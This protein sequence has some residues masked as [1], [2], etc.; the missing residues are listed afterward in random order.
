[1]KKPIKVLL[2]VTAIVIF[3]A[4]VVCAVFYFCTP[5]TPWYNKLPVGDELFE[6]YKP[7]GFGTISNINRLY[8]EYD[9][10]DSYF[11]NADLVIIGYPENTFTSE[12]HTYY[13]REKGFV[14]VEDDWYTLDT[15]RKIK[16]LD[17]LK[18][19]INTKSINL[20]VKEVAIWDENG[21]FEIKELDDFH[22]IQK[23][24]VKYIFILSETKFLYNGE[25]TYYSGYDC[26][27][28][29]DGLHTS[30]LK[31]VTDSFFIGVFEKCKD[32]FIKYNR[33]DEAVSDLDEQNYFAESGMRYF[34]NEEGAFEY[35]DI[36]AI[37]TPKN[38]LRDDGRVSFDGKVIKTDKEASEYKLNE[39]FTLRDMN[40]L[41]VIKGDE[42]ITD[43]YIA[44]EAHYYYSTYKKA[45]DL[46]YGQY[47]P[48]EDPIVK[49]GAVYLYYLK[50]DTTLGENVYRVS[51]R[52]CVLNIDGTDRIGG[53]YNYTT[54]RLY[55]LYMRNID[56]IKEYIP[57]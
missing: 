51:G 3:I 39:V 37:V 56:A 16:V 47:T 54:I 40:V 11:E 50:K 15:I 31:E 28:N 17:V 49:K 1:M 2:T 57:K 35:S 19:E 9:D 23:K 14:G 5:K 48:R 43:I 8:P 6:T 46:W 44:N 53:L 32:Y 21:N 42:N 18:G 4:A 20:H 22:F 34:K 29:I 24:N 45:P 33:S 13:S 27:I 7:T 25:K 55:R 30:S 41:K 36:V 38:D 12:S 52:Q 26:C 10:V